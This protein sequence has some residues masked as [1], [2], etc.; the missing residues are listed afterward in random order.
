M[1]RAIISLGANTA[2]AATALDSA[3]EL[4]GAYGTITRSSGNFY[5][6][7]EG[8]PG[9]P[10]YLNNIVELDTAMDY[11]QL[12]SLTKDYEKQ[13]RTAAAAAPLV[14]ID[15]DIVVFDGTVLRPE[16]MQAQYFTKGM[17]ALSEIPQPCNP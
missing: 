11:R 7:A 16:M 4:L 9:A 8:N 3:L 14:A 5:A 6:A 15:I 10:P 2:T 1:N 13:A 12:Q 17:R